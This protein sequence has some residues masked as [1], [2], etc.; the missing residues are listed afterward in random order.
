MI[1]KGLIS[2]LN[3]QIY[4]IWYSANRGGFFS[5]THMLHLGKLN[6]T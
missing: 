5:Q 1:L 4:K 6:I 2:K 3:Q